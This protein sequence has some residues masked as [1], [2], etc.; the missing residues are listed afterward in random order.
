MLMYLK[1]NFP[2][3]LSPTGELS[4]IYYLGSDI[5]ALGSNI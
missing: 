2:D 3:T 4:V 5:L 1:K